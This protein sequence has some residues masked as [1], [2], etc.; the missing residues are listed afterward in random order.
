M[1]RCL[2]GLQCSSER[3]GKTK[4]F[5]APTGKRNVILGHSARGLVPLPNELPLLS[6][7]VHFFTETN[8]QKNSNYNV[9]QDLHVKSNAGLPLK[10][11]WKGLVDEEEVVSSYL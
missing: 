1:E 2:G 8:K 6:L 11:R 9:V 7:V 10:A 3:F 5:L 4:I